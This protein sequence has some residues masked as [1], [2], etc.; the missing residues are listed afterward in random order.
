MSGGTGGMRA[1]GARMFPVRKPLEAVPFDWFRAS[2]DEGP[3][4][5]G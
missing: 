3:G 4:L 5:V 2:L 1:E